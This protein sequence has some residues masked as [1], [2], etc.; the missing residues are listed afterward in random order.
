MLDTTIIHSS[1]ANLD[2]TLIKRKLLSEGIFHENQEFV[3]AEEEYKLFLQLCKLY[4]QESL[5]ISEK[6]DKFW[7]YHIL[8]TR[9]YMQDCDII[10]GHYLH[11]NPNLLEGSQELYNVAVNTARIKNVEL[12]V[13]EY[14]GCARL[15][16]YVGC[17]RVA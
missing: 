15:A 6:A 8:D 7:H 2:L 13:T 12:H 3:E 1:I 16:D 17:A 5:G 9:K 10:F 4:P 11:H 14:V